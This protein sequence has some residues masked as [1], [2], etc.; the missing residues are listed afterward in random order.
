MKRSLVYQHIKTKKRRENKV[1]AEQHQKP[2]RTFWQ[3]TGVVSV[4]KK[5]QQMIIK[6]NDFGATKADLVW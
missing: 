4:W 5:K 3:I 1:K 6:C 2:T